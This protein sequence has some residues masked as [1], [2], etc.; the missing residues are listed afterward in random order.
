[1]LRVRSANSL[2]I[3]ASALVF[4]FVQASRPE[5]VIATFALWPFGTHA[6]PELGG[7]VGFAPWQLVTYAFLHGNPLHLFLNLFAL[8]MLGRE[9][10]QVLGTARYLQLYFAAVLTAALTQLVVVSASGEPS[11]TVGASGGVFGVLLTFAWLYP[12]RRIVLLFPPVPMPAWAFVTLYGVVE[13]WL[14]VSGTAAGIAHFAH[15][16]GMLGAWIVLVR[17][18]QGR[19]SGDPGS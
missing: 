3:L 16:G 15:L 2:L 5:A 13:L 4:F 11:P 17:W 14:G 9:C 18:R 8:W 10:E 19:I 12:R 1:M 7:T 6:V